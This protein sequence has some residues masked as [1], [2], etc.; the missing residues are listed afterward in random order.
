MI[1]PVL[2][3]ATNVFE[4]RKIYRAQ[5]NYRQHPPPHGFISR[6]QGD[7]GQGAFPAE[8]PDDKN[9]QERIDQ[10]QPQ[11]EQVTALGEGIQAEPAHRPASGI[12]GILDTL[13]VVGQMGDAAEQSVKQTEIAVF[14]AAGRDPFPAAFQSLAFVGD[15]GL[16][17]EGPP[18][19]PD[20][21]QDKRDGHRADYAEDFDK[22]RDEL[23]QGVYREDGDVHLVAYLGLNHRAKP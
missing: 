6:E 21:G 7:T 15:A 9:A 5:P 23:Y 22:L 17:I 20:P 12:A 8:Q 10:G 3:F 16:G 4:D 11:A 2:V 1:S 18:I 13:G 19:D 14:E